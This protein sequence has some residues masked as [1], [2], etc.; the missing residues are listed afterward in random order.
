LWLEFNAELQHFSE[1]CVECLVLDNSPLVCTTN[2][3]H[4]IYLATHCLP[5]IRPPELT[6]LHTT[7]KQCLSKQWPT[8]NI[9]I[10]FY[11]KAKVT[12]VST[13]QADEISENKKLSL[14]DN[15]LKENRDD[16]LHLTPYYTD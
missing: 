7:L 9:Q 6:S 16:V 10:R 15:M 11:I 2:Q 8:P 1:S 14:M 5:Y 4:Q 3:Y 13:P 12:Q